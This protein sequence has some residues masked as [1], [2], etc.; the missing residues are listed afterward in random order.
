MKLMRIKKTRI[1]L[2]KS[3]YTN[4]IN[5]K[6]LGFQMEMKILFGTARATIVSSK[7]IF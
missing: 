6:D 4:I 1:L 7:Q 3:E 2:R 5:V